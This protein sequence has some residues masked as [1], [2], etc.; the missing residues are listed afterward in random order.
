MSDAMIGQVTLPWVESP[1]GRWSEAI[2]PPKLVQAGICLALGV[3]VW[4]ALARAYLHAPPWVWQEG[5]WL[6]PPASICAEPAAFIE[7]KW[8]FLKSHE[9]RSLAGYSLW[10][11]KESDTT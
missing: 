1:K 7:K 8:D 6:Y 9:Q 2:K 11:H 4:W 10:G 3:H 5:S